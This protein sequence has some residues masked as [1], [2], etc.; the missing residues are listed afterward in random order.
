MPRAKRQ[1]DALELRTEGTIRRYSVLASYTF[2]RL[3]WQL[4]GTGKLRR[5]GPHGPEY[6]AILR[7]A[8]VLL[9]QHR[10][11]AQYRRPAGDGSAACI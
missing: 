4:C 2:S 3:V 11:S 9:R 1:Y 10:E 8:D 6:L 7:S 5:S